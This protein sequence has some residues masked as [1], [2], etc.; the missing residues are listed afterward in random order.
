MPM[1]KKTEFFRTLATICALAAVWGQPASAND[2]E[3][4]PFRA[5]ADVASAGSGGE[6][7]SFQFSLGHGAG[8]L[9]F[10]GSLATGQTGALTRAVQADETHQLR[11]QAGYEFGQTT[12]FVTVGGLQAEASSGRR[13]GPLFGLGMRVSLNRML[14]V[15]GELLHHEAGPRDGG[16]GRTGETLSVSAAFRF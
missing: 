10:G 14:Q 11:L 2:D 5:G 15:T 16:N 12:G 6:A 9:L 13:L 4:K 8:G 1:V 7:R 3:R